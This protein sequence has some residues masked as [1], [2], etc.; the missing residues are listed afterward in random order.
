ME[1]KPMALFVA[2]LAAKRQLPGTLTK[3]ADGGSNHSGFAFV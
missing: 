2:D 1:S 3:R